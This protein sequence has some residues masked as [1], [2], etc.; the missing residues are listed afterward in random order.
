MLVKLCE[1]LHISDLLLK[2]IKNVY[3]PYFPLG[4]IFW[5]YMVEYVVPLF[6]VLSTPTHLQLNKTVTN[7]SVNNCY[8]YYFDQNIY[9][10][11]Y[12]YF[13]IRMRQNF[14]NYRI[15]VLSIYILK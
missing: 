5:E 15:K 6:E 8:F 14:I 9:D 11:H 12:A 4:N 3:E 13:L 10:L 1:R 2:Q 7:I